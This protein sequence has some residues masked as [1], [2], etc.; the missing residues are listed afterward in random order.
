MVAA[1]II[2]QNVND[3]ANLSALINGVLITW[4]T[5]QPSITGMKRIDKQICSGPAYSN[6]TLGGNGAAKDDPDITLTAKHNFEG[7]HQEKG[8]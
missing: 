6:L 3:G 4:I 1:V 5:D 2:D 8:S 7:E